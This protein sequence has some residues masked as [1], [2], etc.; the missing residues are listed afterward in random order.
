MTEQLSLGSGDAP[1]LAEA[2][3]N[4]QGVER[5][6][7]CPA[8][9]DN[10]A[11]ASVNVLKRVWYCYACF[12]KGKVDSKAVPKAEELLAM[13]EPEK[14]TRVYPET[15]LNWFGHGFY[16]RDRFEPWL[17]YLM[18]FGVDP[19]SADAD[20][21]F[22]VYTPTGRLAGVGRRRERAE[23]RYMYPAGW[24]ASRSL[25]GYV[26]AL[27]WPAGTDIVILGEGA[28][29]TGAIYETGPVGLGCYGAGIHL[30]QIEL[31]AR[32]NPKL[33]LLGF[34]ADDAG[35]TAARRSASWLAD[36]VPTASIDWSKVGGKDPAELAVEARE[37]A[38]LAAVTDAPYSPSVDLPALWS[39]TRR[40]AADAYER[41]LANA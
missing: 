5:P 41:E 30:P 32:L 20:A 7:R 4:G 3:F 25:A 13:L 22:P 40:D 21:T 14:T 24:S 33:V 26:Q 15:W 31:L 18:R 10:H 37:E 9:L 11:S 19:L 38:I 34:D 27:V 28:A 36:L 1:S 16:W 29:D 35:R 23:Q 39:A 17:C 2:M 6:F 12:A 8:H